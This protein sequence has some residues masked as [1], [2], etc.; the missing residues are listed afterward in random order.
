MATIKYLNE[1]NKILQNNIATKDALITALEEAL[2]D[3]SNVPTLPEELSLVIV[4]P[5]SDELDDNNCKGVKINK[6]PIISH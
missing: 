2:N 6:D 5:S 1:A 3:R 4:V